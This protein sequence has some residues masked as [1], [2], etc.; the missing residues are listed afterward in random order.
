MTPCDN[1]QSRVPLTTRDV[2]SLVKLIVEGVCQQKSLSKDPYTLVQFLEALRGTNST[3]PAL[4]SLPLYGKGTSLSKHDLERLLHMMVL[5]NIL[6]ED[7]RIGEHDNV[8]CYIKLGEKAYE[9]TSGIYGT[10]LLSI[11][12]RTS[13]SYTHLTLPTKRIV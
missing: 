8:V 1:C 4:R 13:V 5:K 6:S 9:V 7:L 10:I 3:K 12:S 2:T 11:R